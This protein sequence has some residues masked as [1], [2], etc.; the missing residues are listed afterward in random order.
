MW[1]VRR[2]LLEDHL[3][4]N[5]NSFQH[6]GYNLTDPRDLGNCLEFS[7]AGVGWWVF[8][9]RA[10]ALLEVLVS[11]LVQVSYQ[12]GWLLLKRAFPG[13]PTPAAS[14]AFTPATQRC[15]LYTAPAVPRV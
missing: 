2:V 5:Q 9:V 13:G 10:A 14:R 12:Q 1:N 7:K 6:R 8:L 4:S 11:N 3:P 15:S